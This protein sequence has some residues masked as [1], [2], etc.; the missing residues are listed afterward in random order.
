MNILP[1]TFQF[2]FANAASEA[3]AIRE[4]AAYVESIS[5][6][7]RAAAVAGVANPSIAQVYN[8]IKNELGKYLLCFIYLSF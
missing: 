5:V 8:F 4:M 2:Q 3:T 7:H 6:Q 1:F